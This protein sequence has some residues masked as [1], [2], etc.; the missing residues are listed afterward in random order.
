VCSSA[1]CSQAVEWGSCV[2]GSVT[3]ARVD[4]YSIKHGSL[5]A[6]V[7]PYVYTWAAVD[8]AAW[9]SEHSSTA[10]SAASITAVLKVS[11]QVT[12]VRVGT[13]ANKHYSPS[14]FARQSDPRSVVAVAGS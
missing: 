9:S 14:A 5:S 3:Y 2:W 7:E 6:L 13:R 12:C 4:Y 10:S 1:A 11:V 8:P